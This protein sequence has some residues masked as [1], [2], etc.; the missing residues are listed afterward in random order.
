M[1]TTI[2]LRRSSI[3]GRVPNTAQLEFGEI[4]INTA[5]GKVY[6]KSGNS[7]VSFIEE[8]S[9]HAADLLTLIKT[10]DGATSGLDADLL[11]GQEGTYYLDY[12]NF[13]NVPPATFD[14][15]LSGKVTGTAFSNTGVMELI[16][17]LANTG[18]TPAQ[19]GSSSQI[20]VITVDEDGRITAASETSVGGVDD[21]TWTVA[22]NTLRIATSDGTNYDAVIN[23]F[24]GITVNGDIAV[25][26]L[27]DGRDIA[28]DGARLDTLET[29]ITVNL[30]GDI[31]G[32]ATS[33]TSILNIVTELANTGVTSG[34]YGSSS[35]V[36]VIT[37]DEDGRITAATTAAVA[38]VSATSWTS[39][40]STFNIATSDGSV[41]ST[42]IS[43]FDEITMIGNGTVDGRDVSADG[44][45]LDGLTVTLTGDIEGT[46]TNNSGTISFVTE[47]ANTGVTADTYGTA[48]AIPVITVDE[49]GRIT[50]ASTT[51]VA[52][53]DDFSWVSANS[54]LVLETGD[55]S[56]YYV[57]VDE[58]DEITVNGNIIITGT[59]DGRDVSVDG[60]KLDL[61]EDGA[62]ADQTAADIRALGFYDTSNDGTG[63]NLDADKL[64]GLH[65]SDILAQA[66]NSAAGQIGNGEVQVNGGNGID[67]SGTFNLNDATD[68]IIT[69]D[70]SDTSSVVDVSLAD[71]NVLTG[72]TFDTYGHVQTTTSTDLDGRYYTE[73]EVDNL[74]DDKVDNTVQV[75]AG[76]ALTGGGA[77]TANVTIDHGD[78][79]SVAD[80][81][82]GTLEFLT[83]ITFDTHGHV[84]TATKETRSFITEA[85][86]DLRYVNVTGDTMSGSLTVN[87]D[88]IQDES[89]SVSTE[90]TTSTIFPQDIYTFD[91][92]TYGSAEI[93]ITAKDGAERHTTKILV[94]HNGS[95]AHATEFAT[96]T[97]SSELAEYDVSLSSGDVKI[98]GTPASS[99]STT[100][101]IVATLIDV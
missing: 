79:S 84:Q 31:E 44:A 83:G 33:N 92:S 50:A 51:A 95:T 46:G 4:A 78:T 41:Y 55:G 80:E 99:N 7:S 60:A 32:S 64:D 18:V 81:T 20:P 35:L 9:P 70:H 42:E 21:F 69:L 15:T 28:A 73:T 74:L 52:G 13:T 11:D 24:T 10:V 53:V 88:I 1:S 62:T 49:D 14:L 22:N 17:E 34:S 75:I 87:A 58:F 8:L 48:S 16:T 12:N 37:V 101:K 59:V 77:L 47:L 39:A 36:P 94:T 43:E 90:V 66:A 61:I 5:D 85:Q 27:V 96:I 54:T 82:F 29:D 3:P 23:E 100:Y 97:T 65:A 30:T 86:G 2:K 63:S 19:Y 6:F 91:A 56:S 67:G 71:G 93:V 98:V 57:T 38:G 45:E 40:N 68:I 25:T 72:V 26:G 76:T 89:R